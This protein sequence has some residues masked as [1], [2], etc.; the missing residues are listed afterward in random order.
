[1]FKFLF[2]SSTTT[3]HKDK[4]Y[5]ENDDNDFILIE[6]EQDEHSDD[7]GMNEV[8]MNDDEDNETQ[9]I[10]KSKEKPSLENILSSLHNS[11]LTSQIQFLEKQPWNSIVPIYTYCKT[12]HYESLRLELLEI[13]VRQLEQDRVKVYKHQPISRL[14]FYIPSKKRMNK[15]NRKRKRNKDCEGQDGNGD[16]N[17]EGDRNAFY[18]DIYY[19]MFHIS[20]FTSRKKKNQCEKHFRKRLA[21]LQNYGLYVSTPCDR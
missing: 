4:N 2:G 18:K 10:I 12:H 8:G 16:E 11:S 5:D 13:I 20:S 17:G 21:L 19:T 6:N 3:K 1:M 7:Y 9:N 15:I 14:V